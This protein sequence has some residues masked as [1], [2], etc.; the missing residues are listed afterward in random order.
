VTAVLERPA[1][2]GLTCSAAQLDGYLAVVAVQPPRQ[3]AS[4]EAARACLERLHDADAVDPLLDVVRRAARAPIEVPNDLVN[5]EQNDELLEDP[6]RQGVN[7]RLPP[8]IPLPRE[9]REAGGG[10]SVRDEVAGCLARMG[11]SVDARLVAR[12]ADPEP[13]VRAAAAIGLAHHGPTAVARLVERAASPHAGTRQAVAAA[14]AIVVANGDLGADGSF[15]LVARLARDVEPGVRREAVRAL[16]LFKGAPA[17]AEMR[18]ALL[19]PD[20]DVRLAAQ[21]A[22][23]GGP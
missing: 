4:W 7:L 17:R 8:G 1:P 6:R 12:L 18:R 13:D 5:L 16:P 22:A 14:L 21:L 11:G 15:R 10:W 20:L 9:L 3:R 2:A 23:G 19:D